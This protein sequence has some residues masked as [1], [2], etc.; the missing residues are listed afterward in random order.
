MALNAQKGVLTASTTNGQTNTVNLPA[1]FDLKALVFWAVN[2]TA[3]GVVDGTIRLGT[4]FAT[5]NGGTIQQGYLLHYDLD[6]NGTSDI[7]RGIN[8]TAALKGLTA[9]TPV[10]DYEMDVTTFSATQF[11]TTWTDAPTSAIKVHY[12]ALGGSDI[13]AARVG[14][15]ATTAAAAT[16]NVTVASGFGQPDLM[17][18]LTNV[19]TSLTDAGGTAA[20][21]VGAAKSATERRHASYY[22]ADNAGNMDIRSWQGNRAI[23]TYTAA[24]AVDSEADLSAKAS[25]PT[26]GFQLSYADQ[27]ASAFQV[28][29]L[30]LKGTFSATIGSQTAPTAAAPQT[31]N[32]TSGGTPKGAL[33]WGTPL[34]TT[35]GV[36]SSHADNGGFMVGATDG[37][38]EGAVGI[39]QDDTN[40]TSIASFWHSESKALQERVAGATTGVLNSEAD[41]SISGN[42]VVL[43]WGDTDTVAREYQYLLLAEVSSST[44]VSASDSVTLGEAIGGIALPGSDSAAVAEAIG[45]IA[46]PA[47][48]SA[49]VAEAIGGI[50]LSSLD[51]EAFSEQA[52]SIELPRSD[53]AAMTE[54]AGPVALGAVDAFTLG[55]NALGQALIQASEALSLSAELADRVVTEFVAANDQATVSEAS[56]ITIAQFIAASESFSLSELSALAASVA[57]SESATFSDAAALAI[58]QYLAGSD[59]FTDDDQATLVASALVADALVLS[60]LSGV[61]QTQFIAALDTFGFLETLAEISAPP[62]PGAAYIHHQIPLSA[63]GGWDLSGTVALAIL[64]GAIIDRAAHGVEQGYSGGEVRA[65]SASGEVTE[66]STD[67]VDL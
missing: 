65:H 49:A 37:T 44:N 56:L 62:S 46:L 47:L 21:G 58:T 13:T 33:F 67:A 7:A 26:D 6:G 11:V 17:L 54:L 48:D 32:L 55:E 27:A 15:F 64:A 20:F 41:S 45:G 29:Y 24:G 31:Q 34:P 3:E 60:E 25:W 9:S 35:A 16:Q 10:V 22:A 43:T 53:S 36:D 12:M 66:V 63:D 57:A 8:T 39:T 2:A 28:V 23:M 30:A 50:G 4:G 19:Q 38:N 14:S 52:P 59:S 1:G 40:T 51:S 42:D 18:F 61:E 5:N